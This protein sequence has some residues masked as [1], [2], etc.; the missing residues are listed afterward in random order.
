[1]KK[2][3]LERKKL[4][5]ASI[6]LFRQNDSKGGMM[7]QINL[8]NQNVSAWIPITNSELELPAKEFQD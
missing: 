2:L 6:L 8:M 7:P 5:K 3:I 1:V 4:K